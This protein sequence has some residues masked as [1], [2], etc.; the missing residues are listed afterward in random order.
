MTSKAF[1]RHFPVREGDGCMKDTDHLSRHRRVH[2]GD[3]A[4]AQGRRSYAWRDDRFGRGQN[5][6]MGWSNPTFCHGSVAIVNRGVAPALDEMSFGV[7]PACPAEFQTKQN[8]AVRIAFS[9]PATAS[10]SRPDRPTEFVRRRLRLRPH[11]KSPRRKDRIRKA[12]D[13][14]QDFREVPTIFVVAESNPK[15]LSDKMSDIL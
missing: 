9:T 4:T 8:K 13:L 6:R 2:L 14:A 15:K 7:L 10:S 3:R 12:C 5:T 11:R 1:L